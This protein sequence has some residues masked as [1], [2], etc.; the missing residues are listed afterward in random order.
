MG[1]AAVDLCYVASGF[2]DGYFEAGLKEWD[3]A[4]GGLIAQEAGAI[5]SQTQAG[6]KL[7]F[8]FEL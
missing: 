5:V 6:I 3:R 7:F 2:F 8:P 1:A 4:A